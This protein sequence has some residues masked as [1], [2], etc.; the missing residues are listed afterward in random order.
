MPWKVRRRGSKWVVV[1]KD[2]TRVMGTHTDRAAA[3]RQLR[4]LYAS[5]KRS[6]R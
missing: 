2:G 1:K 4:A 3:D 6:G 5:Y